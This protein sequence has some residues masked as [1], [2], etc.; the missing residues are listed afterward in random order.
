MSTVI[1]CVHDF[2]RGYCEMFFSKEALDSDTL[3]VSLFCACLPADSLSGA[4]AASYS[5]DR[6]LKMRADTNEG[7]IHP[8]WQR[9]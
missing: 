7:H 3:T 5:I 6:R 4:R 2:H 9:K 8:L 1:L